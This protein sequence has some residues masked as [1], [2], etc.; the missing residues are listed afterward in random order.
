MYMCVFIRQDVKVILYLSTPQASGACLSFTTSTTEGG[1]YFN[2]SK[3]T[4][5]KYARSNEIFRDQYI[6]SLNELPPS[7]D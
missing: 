5:L 6:L 3:T 2:C 1:Y 7:S 4:I